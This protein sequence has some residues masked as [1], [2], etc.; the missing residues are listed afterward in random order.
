MH[1]TAQVG[2]TKVELTAKWINTHAS[3][4]GVSVTSPLKINGQWLSSISLTESLSFG[5]SA[6]GSTHTLGLLRSPIVLFTLVHRAVSNQVIGSQISHMHKTS[7]Y[8]LLAQ[9][10]KLSTQWL[11]Q[12]H[13]NIGFH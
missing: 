13:H 4:T 5:D 8:K 1:V 2:N 12:H 3:A 11:L 7:A 10:H 9:A 6:A